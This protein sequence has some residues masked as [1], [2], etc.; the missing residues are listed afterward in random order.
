MITDRDHA[1]I[2]A[3][4]NTYTR[5]LPSRRRRQVRY[6]ALRLAKLLLEEELRGPRLRSASLIA[7]LLAERLGR[8]VN[9]M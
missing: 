9:A 8:K 7:K 1:K 2:T 5:V 4:L 3:A 6:L